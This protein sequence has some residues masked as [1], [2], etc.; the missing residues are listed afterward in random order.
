METFKKN[1]DY[2]NYVGQAL[3]LNDSCRFYDHKEELIESF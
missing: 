3:K 1:A 2:K